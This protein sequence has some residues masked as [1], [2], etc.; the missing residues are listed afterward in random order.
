MTAAPDTVTEAEP[1]PQ[2]VP[3]PDSLGYWEA[4]TQG[5]LSIR[6]CQ[7]CGHWC[8]PPL[9]RCRLCGGPTDYQPV[10]GEGTLY[11]FITIHQPAVPGYRDTVPYLVGL[12]DLV[13]QPGL[14][15]AARLE[16][17]TADDLRAGQPMVARLVPHPGG[18]FWVPRF[19]PV[20]GEAVPR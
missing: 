17:A 15:I 13:E 19:H 2:P 3:D 8:H 4:M 16:E 9:E 10:S 18:D 1:P 11:S 5:Q 14:R 7:D 20:A 6:R 12:I